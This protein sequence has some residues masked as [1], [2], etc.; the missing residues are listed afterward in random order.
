[1]S[2]EGSVIL[3]SCDNCGSE[4][5]GLPSDT[6]FFCSNCGKCWV[7]DDGLSRVE[8]LISAGGAKGSIHLP[9]WE[10]K[11][12]VEVRNRVT[13][14]ENKRTCSDGPRYFTSHHERGLSS[15]WREVE[16]KS[17][18]LPA[19]ATTRVLS[20]GVLLDGSRPSLL[21]ITDMDF[22]LVAGGTTTIAD[23]MELARGVAVG[24]EVAGSDYLAMVDIDFQ[25][26]GCRLLALPC[27]PG[28]ISLMIS[29]SGVA[30]PFSSM[31]DW[32]E[33]CTWFGISS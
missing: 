27:L 7:S 1:M 32:D 2:S 20:T 21:P 26:S 31:P 23:A 15:T 10:V 30:I 14:M 13:R 29:D 17:I 12:S 6:I 25:P 16:G 4:L 22:P 5:S 24:I 19:F 28:S 33:I 11:A 3:L 8:A 18:I 9:F